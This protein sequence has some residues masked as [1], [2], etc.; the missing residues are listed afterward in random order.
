MSPL[1]I[2]Y[3]ITFALFSPSPWNAVLSYNHAHSL[4]LCLNMSSLERPNYPI[5]SLTFLIILCFLASVHFFF[6]RFFTDVFF[7]C[8]LSIEIL[9]CHQKFKIMEADTLSHSFLYLQCI[10]L[11]SVLVYW[12]MNEKALN[13]CLLDSSVLKDQFLNYS[14]SQPSTF[15]KCS[16]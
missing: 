9:S 10:E 8:V 6:Y 14:L 4:N 11:C 13:K 7:I 15:V 5:C 12:Q 16:N 3:L 2:I 1:I